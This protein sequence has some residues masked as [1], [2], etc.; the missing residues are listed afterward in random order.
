M[1]SGLNSVQS[2]WSEAVVTGRWLLVWLALVLVA[3]PLRP[4]AMAHEKQGFVVLPNSAPHFV[5][6]VGGEENIADILATNEQTGGAFGVWRYTSALQGG[7]PLHIHR[8]EDEFFYVVKGEFNFQL[9][10]CITRAPAGSFVFIPKD[11]VHTFQHIGEETGILLGTVHPGGFEGLFQDLPGADAERVKALFKKYHMD[12][13][14]P[15]LEA[16]SRPLAPAAAPAS[17]KVFRIGVLS[18]GCNPPTASL[19][20]LLQGL[21]DAGYV[22]G[23]N[24]AIEWR[25][26]EG[27]PERFPEMAAELTHLPVDLIVAVSTPAALAAKD[28]TRTVPIVMIY[29]ADPVGTGLVTSLSR[30]GGN[31]TGVSDMATDLSGKR[32]ELLKEA[33]PTLN[34]VAVLWNAADPGMVLRFREIEAAARTL[35]VLLESVEVRS[36]LDFKRAFTAIAQKPPDALFV[37]AEVLT[38]AHRCQVLDFAAEQRLPAIYEFGVF[39][40]EG[41]LMAYGPKLTDTFQRGAYYVDQ[42]LKATKPADLPVEQPMKFEFVI[43]FKTA[44][45]LG[46][47]LPAHLLTLAD[48]EDTGRENGCSRIW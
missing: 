3:V 8:A 15:P 13:V 20:L 45:A 2:G 43:N 41:G 26:S 23:Q 46:L 27:R 14:G 22:E 18:P 34:R 31:I 11:T 42:I 17:G 24:L 38:L 19:D 36:P 12:V 30:P 48:R 32:L 10:D 9:G 4:T 33:V 21:R 47:T 39:A 37:V 44:E 1:R 35:G 6:P 40:R 29:V 16:P 5:G 7:P 25:Y 28:A